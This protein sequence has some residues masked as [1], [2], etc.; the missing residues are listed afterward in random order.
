MEVDDG[1]DFF[2]GASHIG[3]SHRACN[4]SDCR[5][6]VRVL[7]CEGVAHETAVGHAAGVGAVGAEVVLGLQVLDEGHQEVVVVGVAAAEVRVP[8]VDAEVVFGALGEHGHKAFGQGEFVP[9]AVGP[10]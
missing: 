6:D 4:G 3:W 5:K 9:V 8:V 2:R 10:D 1:H 7:A